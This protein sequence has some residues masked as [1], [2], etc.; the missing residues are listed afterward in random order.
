ML[1]NFSA[2]SA[3]HR[4]AGQSEIASLFEGR[5]LIISRVYRRLGFDLAEVRRRCG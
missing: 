1:D 4:I 5:M 3:R 2:T